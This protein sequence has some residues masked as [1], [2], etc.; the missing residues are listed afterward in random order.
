MKISKSSSMRSSRRALA[1]LVLAAVLSPAAIA[2]QLPAVRD[3]PSVNYTGRRAGDVKAELEGLWG[4]EETNPEVI[5][6]MKASPPTQ[7]DNLQVVGIAPHSPLATATDKVKLT[8]GQ[9]MHVY[10]GGSGGGGGGGM[11]ADQRVLAGLAIAGWIGV[12]GLSYS[13]IRIKKKFPR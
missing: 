11:I 13:L 3:V 1:A 12:I 4:I 5:V 2:K 10:V 9:M 6:V 7:W 8:G